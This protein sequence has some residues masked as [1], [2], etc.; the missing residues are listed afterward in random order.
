M[1]DMEQNENPWEDISLEDYEAHMSLDSVR[2]LQLMNAIMKV[3]M[4]PI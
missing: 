3:K 1:N 4:Y 2:Q